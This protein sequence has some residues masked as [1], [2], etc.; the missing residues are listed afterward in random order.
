VTRAIVNAG[1]NIAVGDSPVGETAWRIDIAPLEKGERPTRHIWLVNSEVATSGD[2]HQ[3]LEFEGT[4][5]SHIIDPHT[6]WGVTRRSS[7]TVVTP[8][9]TLADGLST[10][11]TVLGPVAGLQLIEDTPG[12]A[13]LIVIVDK[14]RTTEYESSRFA[15]LIQ[16]PAP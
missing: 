11:V 8:A 7:V 1:G 5:Y 12:A 4:R 13:A 2:V 10:A 14:D 3:Y 9:G 15:R 16:P 6:G